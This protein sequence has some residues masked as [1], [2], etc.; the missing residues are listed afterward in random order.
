[1][2]GTH[3]LCSVLQHFLSVPLKWHLRFLISRVISKQQR[4]IISREAKVW[5]NANWSRK[6]KCCAFPSNI[7]K[8]IPLWSF[9]ILAFA[10][11]IYL[12]VF[13]NDTC[14]YKINITRGASLI[15]GVDLKQQIKITALFFEQFVDISLI[16]KD[17]RKWNLLFLSQAFASPSFSGFCVHCS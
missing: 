16:Y 2:L 17:L 6:Y 5:M 8:L 4:I 14:N 11:K 9:P 3:R 7:T 1:M 12:L 13:A 15:S 10:A